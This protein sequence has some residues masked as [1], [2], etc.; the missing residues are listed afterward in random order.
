[1]FHDFSNPPVPVSP[2]CFSQS[3]LCRSGA[4]HSGLGLTLGAVAAT[5]ASVEIRLSR[6]A[7]VS[8]GSR[9]GEEGDTLVRTWYIRRLMARASVAKTENFSVPGVISVDK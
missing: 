9:L 4:P 8:P 5:R 2:V 1:M 3:S 6:A 7:G